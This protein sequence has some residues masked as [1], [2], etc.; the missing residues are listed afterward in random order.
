MLMVLQ[1]MWFQFP[2]TLPFTTIMMAFVLSKKKLGYFHKLLSPWISK[3]IMSIG[4]IMVIFVPIH[5]GIIY[6][7][8]KKYGLSNHKSLSATI[9]DYIHSWQRDYEDCFG[10]QRHIHYARAMTFESILLMRSN[11]HYD[12]YLAKQCIDISKYL[13]QSKAKNHHILFLIV[14]NNF[15]GEL[16]LLPFAKN[17]FHNNE[18][19][20]HTWSV[21]ANELSNAAPF[22]SDL[23][24]PFLNYLMV[25]GKRQDLF[26]MI[27]K[28]KSF[29]YNMP[30]V[31][32]FEGSLYVQDPLWFSKG[33][34]LLKKK[35]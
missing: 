32:W 3:M 19:F 24:I 29:S 21:I 27:E 18:D 9:H 30:I 33:L 13:S 16:A 7:M 31:C 23:L 26:H 5:G 22:R 35:Y 11:Q 28:L 25:N 12:P 15:L 4:L 2:S 8:G 34:G 6:T 14:P 1:T 20:F 10:G 17:Y